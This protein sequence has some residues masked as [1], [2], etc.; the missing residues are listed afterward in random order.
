MCAP[1]EH[2][3]YVLCGLCLGAELLDH[4]GNSMFKFWRHRHTV[5]HSHA[6]SDFSTSS[7]ALT[8]FPFLTTVLLLGVKCMTLRLQGKGSEVSDRRGR[9]G[10]ESAQC[11]FSRGSDCPFRPSRKV[12][13]TRLG[14]VPARGPPPGYKKLASPT[15]DLPQIIEKPLVS[16]TLDEG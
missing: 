8:S 16:G 7:A 3:R 2:L 5:F 14:L 6:S 13:R 10:P 12:C 4:T 15:T 1:Q 11:C 9:A